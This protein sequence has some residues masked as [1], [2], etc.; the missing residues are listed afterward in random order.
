MKF[1]VTSVHGIDPIFEPIDRDVFPEV[2]SA[3]NV[4]IAGHL[5]D[6]TPAGLIRGVVTESGILNPFIC[7]ELMRQM[8][9]S[10]DL[11]SRLTTRDV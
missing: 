1:D 2:A 11:L 4:T 5:F 6:R 3:S 7:I 10:E 8:P 9:V